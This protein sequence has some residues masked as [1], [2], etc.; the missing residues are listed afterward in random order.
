MQ[1]TNQT[2]TQF[3][4]RSGLKSIIVHVSPAAHEKLVSLAKLEQR[5]MQLV[6]RAI[7]EQLAQEP[8]RALKLVGEFV[9]SEAKPVRTR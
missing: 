5:S 2:G 7:L 6:A 1:P 4:K 8:E 9:K 3:Y